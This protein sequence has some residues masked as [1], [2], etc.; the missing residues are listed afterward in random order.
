[1]TLY[2]KDH[3]DKTNDTCINLIKK[4]EKIK[5]THL[6]PMNIGRQFWVL[7]QH[8]VGNIF[9]EPFEALAVQLLFQLELFAYV[10]HIQKS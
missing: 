5:K 10:P 9:H 8:I 1:M 6:S 7:S 3:V 2:R 4:T